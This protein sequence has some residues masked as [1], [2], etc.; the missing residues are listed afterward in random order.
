MDTRPR[1]WI[2]NQMP[3][4]STS[5]KAMILAQIDAKNVYVPT[6]TRTQPCR[7]VS[8]SSMGTIETSPRFTIE[9]FKHI[10]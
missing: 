1:A 2:S 10:P 3:G 4:P 5:R 9:C 7:Y 6:Y 8:F